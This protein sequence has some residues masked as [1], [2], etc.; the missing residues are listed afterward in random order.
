MTGIK[1]E[2]TWTGSWLVQRGRQH[3]LGAGPYAERRGYGI[4]GAQKEMSER[5]AIAGWKTKIWQQEIGSK[6]EN[7]RNPNL[8]ETLGCQRKYSAKWVE[9]HLHSKSNHHRCDIC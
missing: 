4:N 5:L 1:R 9:D 8:H 7:V 2:T 6:L 3:G